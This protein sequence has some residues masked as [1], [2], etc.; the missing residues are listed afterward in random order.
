[1]SPEQLADPAISAL[2]EIT[3]PILIILIVVLVFF[4]IALSYTIFQVYKHSNNRIDKKEE[5][6]KEEIKAREKQI[7]EAYELIYKNSKTDL[8]AVLSFENKIDDHLKND[9]FALKQIG[10]I[11]EYANNIKTQLE[12]FFK[13]SNYDNHDKRA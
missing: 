4:N 11:K 1:M 8:E 5:T 12:W 13:T 10:I 3:N 9:E 6:H 2:Y 7:T